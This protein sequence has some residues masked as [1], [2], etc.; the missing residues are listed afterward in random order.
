[1][2]SF[3]RKAGV[4]PITVSRAFK[5]RAPTGTFRKSRSAHIVSLSNARA[6]REMVDHL[7]AADE[8]SIAFLGGASSR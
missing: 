2:A 7:V 4:S 1:M 6:T 5:G 3:G 8:R